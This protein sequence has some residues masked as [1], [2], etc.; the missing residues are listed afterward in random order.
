MGNHTFI[1]VVF[2][3][4]QMMDA[5]PLTNCKRAIDKYYMLYYTSFNAKNT[6]SYRVCYMGNVTIKDVAKLAGVSIAT[7]SR[8]INDNYY[9]SP[10]IKEKV[11]QAI[12]DLDYYPNYVARS[13]KSEKTNS[14]GFLVSDISNTYFTTMAKAL[15]DVIHKKNYSLIVCSTEDKKEKELAYLKL[16]ISKKVDG[17]ILNTTGKNDELIAELSKQLPI[18]LS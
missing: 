13:L 7:V 15:E 14:I 16:L 11:L 9:V 3:Q 1:S 8:V 12:E 2:I 17:L 6:F 5:I 4:R 10:E 18:V